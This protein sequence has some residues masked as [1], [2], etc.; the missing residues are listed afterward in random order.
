MAEIKK[1]QSNMTNESLV[2]WRATLRLL[3]GHKWHAGHRFDTPYLESLIKFYNLIAKL[4]TKF[5]VIM[6]VISLC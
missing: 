6:S 4:T 1:N 5:S 2:T 3:S